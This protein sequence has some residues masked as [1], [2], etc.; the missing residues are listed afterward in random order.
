[1]TIKYFLIFTQVWGRAGIELT[2]RQI[3]YQTGLGIVCPTVREIIHE[4]LARG[5]S[6]VQ[7]DNPSTVI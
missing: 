2:T 4:P 6:P 1:M 5:L 3:Q 7:L